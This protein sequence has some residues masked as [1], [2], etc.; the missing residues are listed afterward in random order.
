MF[1][2]LQ[3]DPF[4]GKQTAGAASLKRTLG[5]YELLRPLGRGGMGEVWLARDTVAD[6]EVALK[7][8]PPELRHNEEAQQQ[9]RVSYQRVYKLA[10]PNICGVKDLVLDPGAGYFLVM[11][12]FDGITLS[13]YRSLY[14]VKHGNFPVV[15]VVRLLMPVAEALDH[16]HGMGL[17]HRDIKPTNILVSTDGAAVRLID[18]QLAAEI[19]ATVSRV[20]KLQ[21]DT[22]GTYPY[23]APEQ[24]RGQRATAASDQYAL[25]MTAYELL[26]G[27]LPFE[28]TGLEMWKAIVTDPTTTYPTIAEISNHAFTVLTKSLS[29]EPKQRYP[30]CRGFV[31]TLDAQSSPIEKPLA[32]ADRPDLPDVNISAPADSHSEPTDVKSAA[33]SVSGPS[34]TPP[35]VTSDAKSLTVPSNSNPVALH[36]TTRWFPHLEAAFTCALVIAS[37]AGVFIASG[38]WRNRESLDLLYRPLLLASV[39]LF[40]PLFDVMTLL[41]RIPRRRFFLKSI[42]V[43]SS[44]ALCAIVLISVVTWYTQFQSFTYHTPRYSELLRR[45][46]FE[47]SGGLIAGVVAAYAP[48]F[49]INKTR[50]NVLLLMPISSILAVFLH[51]SLHVWLQTLPYKGE[52]VPMD[53][54]SMTSP[55]PSLFC[56]LASLLSACLFSYRNSIR[57]ELMPRTS[58]TTTDQGAPRPATDDSAIAIKNNERFGVR[59]ILLHL[60]PA[61]TSTITIGIAFWMLH[62]LASTAVPDF[63]STSAFYNDKPSS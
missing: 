37:W 53:L 60:H 29:V 62:I 11:D 10:H 22:S 47:L 51:F 36:N 46:L 5:K 4:H 17:A 54:S 25:A 27:E 14:V 63:S 56:V 40:V 26:A 30:T 42:C 1:D 6:V 7:M 8:L 55:Y 31:T 39:L 59:E 32:V 38:D 28:A 21:F 35:L 13:K 49:M 43:G 18:F 61:L 45:W 9:V 3:D 19:R 24:F 15:E 41:R 57:R 23:Q 44:I 12:Y 2:E 34:S 16:A 48:I 33:V 20:T 58:T 52:I 50:R